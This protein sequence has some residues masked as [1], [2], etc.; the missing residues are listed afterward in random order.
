MKQTT[1]G[2]QIIQ[3]LTEDQ[4]QLLRTLFKTNVQLRREL[5]R[6]DCEKVLNKY[7]VL[8]NLGW[9]KVKNTI[10]NWITQEKRKMNLKHI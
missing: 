4:A 2:R 8:S 6:V 9:I 7:S 3:R 5:R 10:H 1:T